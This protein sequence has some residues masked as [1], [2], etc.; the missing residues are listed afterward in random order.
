MPFHIVWDG[1]FLIGMV[2]ILKKLPL[3]LA[4]CRLIC[5]FVMV[6]EIDYGT[7]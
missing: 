3:L 2:N 7:T 4:M 6:L 5:N 1:I